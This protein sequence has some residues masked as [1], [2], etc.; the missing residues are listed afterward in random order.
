MHRTGG[1]AKGEPPASTAKIPR[2]CDVGSFVRSFV[3]SI[4]CRNKICRVANGT[5][6][7]P[8]FPSSL[9]PRFRD[10]DFS[11]WKQQTSFPFS[12]QRFQRIEA[13]VKC[14]SSRKSSCILMPAIGSS[15]IEIDDSSASTKH[16][17]LNERSDAFSTES[18]ES[19]VR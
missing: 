19:R 15:I 3:R 10:F 16:A 5:R 2:E 17:F 8:G 18:D 1:T 7:T 4:V 14:A 9:V 12:T 13:R 6:H 11:C